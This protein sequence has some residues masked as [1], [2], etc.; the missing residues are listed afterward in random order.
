VIEAARAAGVHDLVCSLPGG[1]DALVGEGGTA[2]SAGQRQRIALARALYGSPF[3]I[4][5]DEPNSNLDAD[6]E[7]AL[8]NAVRSARERGAIVVIMA[9]RQS[10]LEVVD[11]IL[12]LDNGF[13]RGFGSRDEVM[14]ALR[15]ANRLQSKTGSLPQRNDFNSSHSPTSAPLRIVSDSERAGT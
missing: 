6:G 12:V 4:V 7:I 1:Y 11:K 15:S 10:V 14:Q 3:L 8:L 9:H 2:L 13:K 5:L